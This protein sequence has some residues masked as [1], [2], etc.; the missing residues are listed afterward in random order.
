MTRSTMQ[1]DVIR[2]AMVDDHAAV[3]LGLEAAISSRPGL[4]SVGVVDGPEALAPLLYRARPDVVILDYRLPRTNGLVLC[5]RV[6][7]Q[8]LHPAVLLY[9][10]YADQALVVPALLAGADGLVHKGGPARELL[11]A[12]RV[13]AGG[14]RW[15]P[16]LSPELLRDA[17]AALDPEDLPVL[18]MLSEGTPRP[19]IAATLRLDAAELDRRIGRMLASLRPER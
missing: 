6:K 19:E 14:G 8:P 5:R 4:V 11:D 15:L 3:R 9:S 2:V 18:G 7:A 13:V 16:P 1:N 10:A 12:I 17:G